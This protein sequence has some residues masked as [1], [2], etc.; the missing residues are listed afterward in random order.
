MNILHVLSQFEVTGAETY[1]AALVDQQA[2]RGHR[3]FVVSDTLTLPFRAACYTAPIG[4]RSYVQRVAN[5]RWLVRFIR[6]NGIQVV[7]AHSRAAS[8]VSYVACALTK[9]PLVSTVHGRQHVHASSR[10]FNIY[11]KHIIAVCESIKDH[12]VRDLGIAEKYIRVV[13]NGFSPLLRKSS[14]RAQMK[15]RVYGVSDTTT[16]WTFVGRFSGPKGDV[17]RFLLRHVL[18]AL[19]PRKSFAFVIVGGKTIPH[20]IPPLVDAINLHQKNCTVVLKGFQ[21]YLHDF[22]SAADLVLGSGRVAIEALLLGKPVVAFGESNYIGLITEQNLPQAIATN[23]G[24]AGTPLPPQQTLVVDELRSLLRQQSVPP[25]KNLVETLRRSYAIDS[26]EAAVERCYEQART[27]TLSPAVIPV[28]LYHRIVD[29]PL[30]GRLSGLA[31]SR[32]RFEEQLR[33]LSRRGFSTITFSDYAAFTRGQR[34]LPQRPIILTFDD[35]YEDNYRLAFPLLQAYRMRAVIY[36]VAERKRRTNFWDSDQPQVPLLTSSQIK[37]MARAGI[38][39]GSHTLSHPHLPSLARA[40][41]FRELSTSKKILEDL[42]GNE[43]LSF[44]YPYGDVSPAVKA[45]VAEA[46]YRYAVA[47]ETGPAVFYADPFEIRRV[48]VFPW[49]NAFGFWKKTQ[50]WYHRYREFKR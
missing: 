39:F 9:T 36:L 37:D 22:L 49:T 18:P 6:R 30:P 12:L 29:T 19:R 3:L 1:A 44:A 8:W 11:G 14:R 16:V 46:G 17:V 34:P 47:G 40:R 35:G 26:V 41:A 28:L 4:K 33:S 50:P 25:S 31:V 13:P 45:L 38:E 7:H 21:E 10:A 42:L 20:D 48:Q 43:L 27:E 5:I 15:R 2:S 23:F 24:D 32:E